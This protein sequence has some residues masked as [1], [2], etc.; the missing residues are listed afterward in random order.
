MLWEVKLPTYVYLIPIHKSIFSIRFAQDDGMGW[1]P[2][3]VVHSI[4][5]IS[6]ETTHQIVWA[7]AAVRY[8]DGRC[9]Y[10]LWTHCVVVQ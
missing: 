10:I 6:F 1:D 8:A 7:T 3:C 2:L 5:F 4:Q 9:V